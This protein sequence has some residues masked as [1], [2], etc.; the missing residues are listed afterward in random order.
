[1]ERDHSKRFKKIVSND[2][3]QKVQQEQVNTKIRQAK[4]DFQKRLNQHKSKLV[5]GIQSALQQ[6]NPI[7]VIPSNMFYFLLSGRSPGD[8]CSAPN[9]TSC[10]HDPSSS[11][12]HNHPQVLLLTYLRI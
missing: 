6:C 2:S 10:E 8:V 12:M 1:M 11:S 3:A 7:L 5:L 4:E 9:G